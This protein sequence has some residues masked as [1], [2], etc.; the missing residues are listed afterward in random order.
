MPPL[1]YFNGLEVDEIPKELELNDLE[2]TLVSKRILF[3]KIFHLPKSRWSAV[4]DKVVNVPISDDALLN[5]LNDLSS[6]PRKPEDAG[7]ICV[8]LKRKL[9]YKNVHIKAYIQAGKL[10]EAV[11]KLKGLDHPGYR[12]ITVNDRFS[13]LGE[14]EEDK[15]TEQEDSDTEELD[16]IRKNQFDLGGAVTMTEFCPKASLIQKRAM[17]SKDQSQG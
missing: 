6:L 3:L 14:E 13:I 4:K 9:E 1:C 5:T 7:L 8:K 11:K 16:S 2:A 15:E 12:H 17:G 10:I